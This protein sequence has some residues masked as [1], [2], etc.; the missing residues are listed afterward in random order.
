METENLGA[1]SLDEAA[2]EVDVQGTPRTPSLVAALLGG[3]DMAQRAAM[4]NSLQSCLCKVPNACAFDPEQ[5]KIGYSLVSCH[6]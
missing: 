6:L 3:S 2:S 4:E 1:D 5:T